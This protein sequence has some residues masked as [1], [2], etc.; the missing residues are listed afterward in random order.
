MAEKLCSLK[1]PVLWV[2]LKACHLTAKD[3]QWC[4][5]KKKAD[6]SQEAVLI[7]LWSVFIACRWIIM[8]CLFYAILGSGYNHVIIIMWHRMNYDQK[9]NVRSFFSATWG[10]AN[11]SIIVLT[12]ETRYFKRTEW[13]C[14]VK[15]HRWQLDD[16][17]PP[18]KS[19]LCECE[20]YP[21]LNQCVF[22][23]ETF[24]K[25]LFYNFRIQ[26]FSILL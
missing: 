8:E 7:Q 3:F 23:Q 17:P 20:I 10:S 21:K 16:A 25:C 4:K 18:K 2:W 9:K 13:K 22:G 26:N 24:L 1:K 15:S 6:M 12:A 19:N 14:M 11:W 5:E